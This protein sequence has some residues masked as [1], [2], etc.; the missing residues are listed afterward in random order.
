MDH[1]YKPVWRFQVNEYVRVVLDKDPIITRVLT[2]NA[3][4]PHTNPAV[5]LYPVVTLRYVVLTII[6]SVTISGPIYVSKHVLETGT[7]LGFD[8]KVIELL[9]LQ[10][11]KGHQ[12]L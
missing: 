9:Y 1:E 4:G 8:R 12:V 11:N 2:V 5:S 7:S 3:P 10:S 6:D